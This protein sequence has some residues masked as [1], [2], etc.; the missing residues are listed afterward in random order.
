[1]IRIRGR[2]RARGQAMV[3]FAVVAPIFLLILFGIIQMGLI[4]GAQNSLTSAVRETARY[5]APYRVVS[6]ADAGPTCATALTV[7]Q[8]SLAANPL[9]GDTAT[10]EIPR[11]TYAW[12]Q[13]PTNAWYVEVTVQADYK[14]PLYVP[15]I[16]N[17]LD[18]IDGTI[19]K[20]LRIS[21]Q[22]KMRIENDPLTSGDTTT[23]CP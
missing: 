18:G 10:R 7:L 6:A 19:D 12:R 9:T 20:N 21:A 11:I 3:E 1:M 13:D 2:A 22:E 14:Y 23:S 5:A 4:M 8:S 16:S 17:I 15:L